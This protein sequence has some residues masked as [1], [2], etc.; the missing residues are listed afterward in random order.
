[1]L[2]HQQI[3]NKV[4]EKRKKTQGAVMTQSPDINLTEMMWQD[5]E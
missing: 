5:L 3:Y 2:E 1:M 4:S